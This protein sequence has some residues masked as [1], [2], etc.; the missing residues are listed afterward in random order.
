VFRP[1]TGTWVPDKL[2]G[3]YLGNEFPDDSNP[4]RMQNKR[5]SKHRST[6]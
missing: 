6:Q 3:W 4:N 2:P 1:A 5:Y